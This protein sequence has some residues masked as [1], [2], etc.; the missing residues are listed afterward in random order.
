MPLFFEDVFALE[1]RLSWATVWRC[2]KGDKGRYGKT[3][4]DKR[5][6]FYCHNEN[7]RYIKQRT[8]SAFE[9]T[10]GE[11]SFCKVRLAKEYRVENIFQFFN[12][13]NEK[14]HLITYIN[15]VCEK[16]FC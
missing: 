14:T 5:R 1:E 9:E 7:I 4:G 11:V 2:S 13:K 15:F 3:A 6:M 8:V 10:Q 16:S 12:L